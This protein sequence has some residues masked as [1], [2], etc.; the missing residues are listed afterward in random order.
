LRSGGG[1]QTS[2]DLSAQVRFDAQLPHENEANGNQESSAIYCL[3]ER[4]I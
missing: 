1:L 2:S 4:L 3:Q